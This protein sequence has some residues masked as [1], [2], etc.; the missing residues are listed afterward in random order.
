MPIAIYCQRFKSIC[1]AL[2]EINHPISQN[3]LIRQICFGLPPKYGII[4]NVINA[5]KPLAD[6]LTI[7]S[8]LMM[9]EACLACETQSLSS[10]SAASQ[11]GSNTTTFV[12]ATGNHSSNNVNQGGN[13]SWNGSSR[14]HNSENRHWNRGKNCGKG[15][16]HYENPHLG[17]SNQPAICSP[18]MASSGYGAHS[19]KWLFWHTS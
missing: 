6:F 10:L 16:R 2:A 11:T 4:V 12:A 17:F 9:E 3:G 1:D 8:M 15:N 18:S 7:R 5:Q 14:R 19:Q 13:R